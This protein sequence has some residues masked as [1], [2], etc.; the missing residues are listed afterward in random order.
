MMQRA[1]TAALAL[2]VYVAAFVRAD[3]AELRMSFPELAKIAS[4]LLSDAKLRLH[5]LPGG[6]F[7]LAAGSYLSIGSAKVPIPVPISPFEVA[8]ARYTYYAN[9]V[10][11]S[12][13]VT[14]AVAG[15]VRLTITFEDKDPELVGRCLSGLCAP[16]SALPQVE[17][18]K[19]SIT[20]E[21][22]PALFESALS[23]EV[24]R[25]DIGGTFEPRCSTTSN[26]FSR[27]VCRVVL[28][29]AKETVARLTKDLDV[30]LKNQMNA[31]EQQ[32]K[33]AEGIKGRLV[34]GPAGEVKVSAVK[35]EG[36]TGVL[37]FCVA[38]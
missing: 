20:L 11:S 1:V 27:S 16:D 15:A 18:E 31:P 22:A 3:A 17:W 8:G 38:C 25:V 37:T 34:V 36:E 30:G 35:V 6:F 28:S 10:N 26:L 7:S 9:E 4:T 29:R 24:K 19:P 5:T 33:L 2:A 13:V 12:S 32:R 23:L 21:V 14:T